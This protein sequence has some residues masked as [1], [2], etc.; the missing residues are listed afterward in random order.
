MLLT[1]GNIFQS[2]EKVFF[3]A[4]IHCFH[5]IRW[6]LR[7]FRCVHISL[8]VDTYVREVS[9]QYDLTDVLGK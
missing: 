5:L 2:H 4:A 3:R 7:A 9:F 8:T 1:L 6:I